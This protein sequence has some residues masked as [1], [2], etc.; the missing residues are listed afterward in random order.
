MKSAKAELGQIVIRPPEGMR[1]RIKALADANGR[2]MNSEIIAALEQYFRL[3]EEREAGWRWVS[4]A[5]QIP[6]I[7]RSEIKDQAERRGTSFR[8]ELWSA[9]SGYF[10]DPYEARDKASR[11]RLLRLVGEIVDIVGHDIESRDRV[12]AKAD[13]A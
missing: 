11:E 13:K 1:E 7:F 4:P 6:E 5:E 3:E 8:E 9:L 10:V 2:S 12:D